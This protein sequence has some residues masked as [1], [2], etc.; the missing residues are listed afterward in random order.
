MYCCIIYKNINF[1]AQGCLKYTFEYI[2][3]FL[4][5]RDDDNCKR[6]LNA[7]DNELAMHQELCEQMS[8]LDVKRNL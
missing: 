3:V 6:S 1:Y 7:N 8:M 2:R 5:Q 4:L